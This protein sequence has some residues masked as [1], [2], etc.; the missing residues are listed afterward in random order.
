MSLISK[1]K[2]IVDLAN[3]Y[4]T[5]SGTSEK[6]KIGELADKISA[7]SGSSS[8]P[9]IM[10]IEITENGTYTASEGIDGYSPIT[11]NVQGASL[12]EKGLV[13]ENYDADGC[14]TTARLFGEWSELKG[15][16]F[17]GFFREGTMLGKITQVPIPAGTQEI[18]SYTFRNCSSLSGTLVIP[19]SVAKIG[20][21]TFRSTS[22]TK[23]VFEGVVPTLYTAV[24]TGC[25]KVTLYDFSNHTGAVPTL[26][27]RT[28]IAYADNCIIKVPMSL[29]LDW[30]TATNWID[31]TYVVWRF[32]CTS[33][34]DLPTASEEYLDIEAEIESDI[35]KCVETST[36]IY[37]WK[38]QEVQV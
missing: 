4:R 2:V 36:G 30:K 3:A 6:I 20:N 1:D 31:L 38:L 37:E 26:Q 22:F 14:P 21:N 33:V 24:F 9:V 32:P 5:A 17:D 28:S 12:P 25:T 16:F 15:W 18:G 34:L 7:L 27:T 23:V 10:P 19:A 13:F 35:Y 11:V 8:D 29:V